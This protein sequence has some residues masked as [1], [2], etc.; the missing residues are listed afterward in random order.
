MAT[1]CK[2]VANSIGFHHPEECYFPVCS[3]LTPVRSEFP[4]PSAL[5]RWMQLLQL[6]SAGPVSSSSYR[7]TSYRETQLDPSPLADQQEVT[8]RNADTCTLQCISPPHSVSHGYSPCF[9]PMEHQSPYPATM[10]DCGHLQVL[11]S[12]S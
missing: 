7:P 8:V 2:R 6:I 9:N 11:V 12:C 3:E 1:P 10:P 5:V 4:I